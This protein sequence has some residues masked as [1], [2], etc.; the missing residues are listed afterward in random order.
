MLDWFV[1]C[2]TVDNSYINFFN[3]LY[4]FATYLWQL[5][6]DTYELYDDP[7]IHSAPLGK[8]ERFYSETWTAKSETII[9][10]YGLN[11]PSSLK[12]PIDE[13]RVSIL[14]NHFFGI[15]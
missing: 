1:Q 10:L 7:K 15:T 6:Y 9:D 5:K 14:K 3:S 11:A 8:I 2:N 12:F 4:V 13:F